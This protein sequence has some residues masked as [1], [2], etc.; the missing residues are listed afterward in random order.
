M[1]PQ[2]LVATPTWN[3]ALQEPIV[4]LKG[5]AWREN[6]HSHGRVLADRTVLYKYVNPNLVSVITQ[7]ADN[8]EHRKLYLSVEVLGLALVLTMYVIATAFQPTSTST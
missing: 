3:L 2:T 5:K 4:S 1:T 7:S 8:S 6:V